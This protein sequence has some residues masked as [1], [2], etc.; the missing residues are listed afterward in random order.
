MSWDDIAPGYESGDRP[1][2]GVA[3][4]FSGELGT[5]RFW[6]D[7]DELATLPAAYQEIPKRAWYACAGRYT[8]DR[9]HWCSFNFGD[10]A[11]T[12]APPAG[13]SSFARL[14]V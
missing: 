13:F 8:T 2:I 7:G 5:I 4:D 6:V 14:A 9:G 1:T 11:F 12:Q 3:L 10:S